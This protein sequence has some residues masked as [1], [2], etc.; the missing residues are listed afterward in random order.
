MDA[1]DTVCH[2]VSNSPRRQ[3]ALEKW[4]VLEGEHDKC[5][6]LFWKTRWV[7]HHEAFEV[8][9]DLFE[10]FAYCLEEMKDSNEWHQDM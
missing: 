7:E 3:L 8:F 6:N 10:P 5:L 4:L 2:F 1:G 9:V